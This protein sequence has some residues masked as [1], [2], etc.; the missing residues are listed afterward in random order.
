MIF[1]HFWRQVATPLTLSHIV[2]SVW[3]QEIKKTGFYLV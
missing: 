3:L 2:I 1:F